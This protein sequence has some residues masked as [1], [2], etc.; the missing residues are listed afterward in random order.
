MIIF[1]LWDNKAQNR[2]AILVKVRQIAAAAGY[3]SLL[4]SVFVGGEAENLFFQIMALMGCE[5][6]IFIF[7]CK[8]YILLQNVTYSRCR[9]WSSPFPKN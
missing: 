5:D 4:Y 6:H 8:D 1:T 9:A 2:K 3:V 7:Y